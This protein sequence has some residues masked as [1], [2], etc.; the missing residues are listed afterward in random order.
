MNQALLDGFSLSEEAKK[1]VGNNTARMMILVSDGQPT[2]GGAPEV[3]RTVQTKNTDKVPILTL[4]IGENTAWQLLQLISETTDSLSRIIY[5]GVDAGAQLENFFYKTERPTLRD[6]KIKYLGGVDATS[7]TKTTTGQMFQGGEKVT[8][9]KTSGDG[10]PLDVE[11]TANSKD[12]KV[13]TTSALT[14][15]SPVW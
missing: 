6:V 9:G 4:G 3:L 14:Q 8:M 2:H 10:S 12:G 15:V 5:D 11:V 1:T 7:L 13:T